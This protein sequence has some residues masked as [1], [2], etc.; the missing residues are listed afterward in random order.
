VADEVAQK[1]KKKSPQKAFQSMWVAGTL[2]AFFTAVI[3]NAPVHFL[4]LFKHPDCE[5]IFELAIRYSYLFWLLFYFF[6][7]NLKNEQGEE[8]TVWDLS[9]DVVQSVLSLTAVFCLG[10]IVTNEGF[11]MGAYRRAVGAVDIA[12]FFICTLA[13]WWFGTTSRN[14]NS[15][16]IIGA[17]IA[18]ASLLSV[19]FIDN[20]WLLLSLV[21]A[22][23]VALWIVLGIFIHH[24]LIPT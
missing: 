12:I 16:R 14:D 2:G 15:L 24:R 22:F 8:P 17:G 11:A 10:F 13:R 6:M 4:Q 7:S 5:Y 20:S 18:F 21:A 19:I 23:L 3:R 9:Y 1:C